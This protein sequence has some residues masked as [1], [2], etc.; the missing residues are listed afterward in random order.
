MKNSAFSQKLRKY[1]DEIKDKQKIKSDE[2]AIGTFIE[3]I[4]KNLESPITLS[5]RAVRKWIN[6][7]SYPDV[8]KLLIISSIFNCTVDD[9]LKDFQK[10]IRLST[11]LPVW[12]EELREEER[13]FVLK[14][15]EN[16]QTGDLSSQQVSVLNEKMDEEYKDFS[17]TDVENMKEVKKIEES[18]LNG[19]FTELYCLCDISEG[20]FIHTDKYY[21]YQELKEK[22]ISRHKKMEQLRLLE[23]Y[24]TENLNLKN[25]N[26]PEEILRVIDLGYSEATDDSGYSRYWKEKQYIGD[27]LLNDMDLEL[28]TSNYNEVSFYCDD[29]LKLEEVIQKE[30]T[31]SAKREMECLVD[32]Q[33]ETMK[34]T[35]FKKLIEKNLIIL[36]NGGFSCLK[37]KDRNKGKSHI[38]FCMKIKL[39]MPESDV[40]NILAWEYKQ[41]LDKR[42][43]ERKEC[44]D[45]QKMQKKVVIDA[46]EK[47]RRRRKKND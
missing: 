20:I 45:I 18:I 16:Y 7:E 21:T 13:R 15:L 28:S 26:L 12:Y 3:E 34:R 44:I 4:N 29:E 27:F 5:T 32:E 22:E 19:T 31:D 43:E 6:G 24:F 2:N 41:E 25:E 11:S 40:R 10:D 30:I 8:E 36:K 14:M 37:F 38:Y 17:V 39:N 33:F 9:L 23:K 1:L 42:K 46:C 47:F 35:S